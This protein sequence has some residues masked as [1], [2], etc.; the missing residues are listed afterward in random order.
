MKNE[1]EHL[2]GEK[3][4][5]KAACA[6]WKIFSFAVFAF[7]AIC[8]MKWMWGGIFLEEFHSDTADILFW[9]DAAYNGNGIAGKDFHYGYFIP[10]GGQLLIEPFIALWGLGVKAL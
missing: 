2:T 5:C 7:A 9:A 10:F 8:V 3:P 1:K 6:I 4:C